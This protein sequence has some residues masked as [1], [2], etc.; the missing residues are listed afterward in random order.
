M[1]AATDDY[2]SDKN[3]AITPIDKVI[4]DHLLCLHTHFQ[5]YFP[6]VFDSEKKSW[7]RKP[8]TIELS[9]VTHL[10]KSQEEFAELCDKTLETEFSKQTLSD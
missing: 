1:F 4:L 6:T 7:I 8:F 5:K 2:L 10:L 9:G 3:L